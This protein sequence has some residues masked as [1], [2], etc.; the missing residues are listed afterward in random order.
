VIKQTKVQLAKLDE[1]TG[2]EAKTSRKSKKKSNETTANANQ[3]D[4]ALQADIQAKL[5]QTQEFTDKAKAKGERAA[6]DMLLLYANLLSVDAK[7][8]WNKIPQE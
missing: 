2:R 7:Y 3:T 5:K 4:L 6:A 1:S 8:S